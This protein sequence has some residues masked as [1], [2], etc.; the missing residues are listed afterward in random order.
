[1]SWIRATVD[2]VEISLKVVPGSSR[3][4]LDGALGDALKLR[5]AAPPQAGAANAAVTR[6][7]AETLHVPPRNVEIVRGQ[8]QPR[9]Q[10]RVRGVTLDAARAALAGA[11]P[12]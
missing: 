5:V 2:G 8:G 3:T 12:P 1:M 7:L 11:G 10:V 9:K 6:V 4:R